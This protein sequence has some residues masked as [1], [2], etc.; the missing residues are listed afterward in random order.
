MSQLQSIAD[1]TTTALGRGIQAIGFG[2][3]GRRPL[4]PDLME[5]CRQVLLS[6]QGDPLQ[7]GAFL[8]AL[9]AKGPTPEEQSLETVFG[10]NAFLNPAFFINKVCPDLPTSLFP[11]ATKLL[12]GHILRASEAHQLGNFLFSDDNC[13]TFKGMATSLLRIRIESNDEYKGFYDAAMETITPGFRQL[14]CVDRPLVQLAEPFDG[15]EHTYLVTPLLAHFFEQRGYGAL[16]VVGRTPGPNYTLN[17]HDLYLYL[18][19]QMLQSNHEINTPPEPFGWVLDQKA[20]SPALNRWVDRR[21]IIL[22]RPFLAT[23]EKILNPCSAR[24]LVTSVFQVPFQMKMAEL[25]LMA[26]FDAVIVMKRGLEG[27][28]SPATSRSSGILCAVRTARGHLFYQNF[29]IDLPAFAEYRTETDEI[30]T[31]LQVSDNVRLIRDFMKD[32]E[33]D[34]E[35]FDNRAHFTQALLGRGMDWIEG[36][37]DGR[38]MKDVRLS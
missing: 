21:R 36:Q 26:G 31:N 30:V 27:S 37:L 8:G 6:D 32:G 34:S 25:A 28:L 2:K 29:D 22:K 33:T 13:E 4:S 24:I 17:A 23:L 15:V 5:E 16:S 20:L 35:D 19:C 10:K 14:S 1:P 12:K 3:L 11:I 7:K 9:L 18:G 38:T